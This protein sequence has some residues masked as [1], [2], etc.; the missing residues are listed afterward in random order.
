MLNSNSS[1]K[2][3]GMYFVESVDEDRD[4]KRDAKCLAGDLGFFSGLAHDILQ[5]GVDQIHFAG[6]LNNV[7]DELLSLPAGVLADM[8]QDPLVGLRL[9]PPGEL[10]GLDKSQVL[11]VLE[12][13]HS[14]SSGVQ[15]QIRQHQYV[16]R[17]QYV[18]ATRSG[19]SVR[20]FRHDF[21]V[22][23]HCVF[24]SDR[25]LLGRRY[26]DVAGLLEHLLYIAVELGPAESLDCS[27]L[28]QV[29]FQLIRE[30][31]V[32]IEERPVSFEHADDPAALFFDE[33]TGPV[34]HVAEALD[35]E[36]LVLDSGG[37]I[38]LYHVLGV[39]H[40]LAQAV[41][42]AQAGGLCPS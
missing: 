34:A 36:G 42:E 30:D 4:P 8:V 28:D 17:H 40:E 2:C 18:L 20:P 13:G 22:K 11:D 32:G 31:S 6:S 23:V 33:V 15:Q 9:Q 35:D 25:P 14:H 3:G 7:L 24:A 27:S 21:A 39:V 37:Q 16:L 5:A 10:P 1:P 12:I 26:D 41:E 19:G 38:H 29:F